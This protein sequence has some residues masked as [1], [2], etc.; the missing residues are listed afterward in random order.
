M[1]VLI[2]PTQLQFGSRL[3]Q[4]LLRRKEANVFVS[5]ASVGL[6]LGM[7]G[8][9]ARGK[10]LA[11]FEHALGAST[12]LLA[13]WSERLLTGLDSL[14]PGVAVE[15]ANS[16]WAPARAPLSAQYTDAMRQR[17]RAEVRNLDFTAPGAA[18]VVNDWVARATRGQIDNAVDH[19]S[20][21][22]VLM[23]VNAI[24]FRGLW[25]DP[26]ESQETVDQEFT[27]GSGSVTEVRMMHRR[28]SFL[29]MEDSDLQAVRLLYQERR[30]S[31]IVVLPRKPLPPEAFRDIAERTSLARIISG[32]DR[33]QGALGLPK[34]RLAYS[35]D[36]VPELVE[37]GL[38][39]A[40][41]QDAD[42]SG[43]FERNVSSFISQVLHKTR[44]EIDEQGT[45]AA[46]STSVEM[47]L[48]ASLAPP[49]RPFRMT[50][51][52]PFL[53]V[54]TDTRADLILFLGVIGNPTS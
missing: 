16:L 53:V 4:Q 5:P 1:A 31:L 23:L 54:L 34:V 30:F 20:P 13:D 24:Y 14:P 37:M 6:A 46:A 44:L 49:P 11:A 18:K 40:F 38:G 41:A 8:A 29:Y 45:T 39:P 9:G 25:Q 26:F 35:A 19:I 43:A 50:V 36:L 27:T 48:S 32:L 12:T 47:S 52:R 28:A 15:I 17:Y 3:L 22:T 21:S 33:R 2:P 7:A 42:F 51:D 10:T